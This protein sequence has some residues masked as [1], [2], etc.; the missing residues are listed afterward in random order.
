MELEVGNQYLLLGLSGGLS[1]Q[2]LPPNIISGISTNI[3]VFGGFF[4]V[5]KA[6]VRSSGLPANMYFEKLG[7]G[8]LPTSINC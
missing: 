8:V 5:R 4:W 2:G 6:P 1:I 7:F 3:F